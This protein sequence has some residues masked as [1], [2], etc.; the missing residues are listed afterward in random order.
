MTEFTG[1]TGT[2]QETIDLLEGLLEELK[3]AH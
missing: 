2:I 1:D 3:N